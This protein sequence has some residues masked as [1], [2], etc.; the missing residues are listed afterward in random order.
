[1]QSPAR[2]PQVVG[3]LRAARRG[4]QG[5]SRFLFRHMEIDKRARHPAGLSGKPLLRFVL[6]H[7]VTHSRPFHMKSRNILTQKAQ[8]RTRNRHGQDAH[9]ARARADSRDGH[10][11]GQTCEQS[12]GYRK[13]HTP[14]KCSAD[15]AVTR[16]ALRKCVNELTASKQGPPSRS[17]PARGPATRR[18]PRCRTHASPD[19]GS[20]RGRRTVP[21]HRGGTLLRLRRSPAPT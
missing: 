13:I 1:V 7:R 19:V 3:G 4:R 18:E 15:N 11:T 12:T 14:H 2:A 10:K 20:K 9:T 16:Q 6:S 5:A 8:P 21:P 17:R